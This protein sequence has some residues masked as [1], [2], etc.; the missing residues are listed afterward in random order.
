MIG[1]KDVRYHVQ[2]P[3]AFVLDGKPGEGNT[4]NL[5]RGGCGIETELFAA[6]GDPISLNLTVPTQAP[7]ILIELGRVRWA[8]KREFGVE[9]MV[10]SGESKRQLNDYLIYLATQG[11]PRS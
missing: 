6:S 4:F 11:A 7:P 10:V 1:R 5:S 8:T 3:V 2:C 9:F